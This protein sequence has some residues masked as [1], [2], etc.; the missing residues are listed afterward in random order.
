MWRCVAMAGLMMAAPAGAVTWTTTPGAPDPEVAADQQLVVSFD[1]AAAAGVTNTVAGLVMTAAG[2]SGGVRAAPAGTRGI[3]QSIGAGGSSLFDFS[4]WSSG[5]PLTSL[6]FYWGSIDG[7]NL[8]DFLD[9]GGARVGGM[10]GSDLPFATGNQTAMSSNRRVFFNFAPMEKVTAL[11]LRSTGAAFEFD[12][13]GA[14]AAGGAVPEPESWTLMIIG[15][16]LAG[17]AVRRQ[18]L[19]KT[20][21]ISK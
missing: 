10:S 1:A 7:Y 4:G 17:A 5:R 16:A 6:S 14:A 18:T 11:R 15:F 12:S 21:P 2:S 3:Y 8:V 20:L 9:A 19:K 13:I